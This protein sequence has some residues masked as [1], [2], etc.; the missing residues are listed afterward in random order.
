M[1]WTQLYDVIDKKECIGFSM[2]KINTNFYN[3]D[4]YISKIPTLDFANL[5]LVDSNNLSDVEDNSVARIN[6]GYGTAS[7]KPKQAAA[8]AWVTFNPDGSIINSYNVSS[9]VLTVVGTPSYSGAHN[10][11]YY[12]IT[13]TTPLE[14]VGPII[15]SGGYTSSTYIS[16]LMIGA[17]TTGYCTVYARDADSYSH[18]SPSFHYNE[19]GLRA[20]AS[21][22]I[23]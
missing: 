8:K 22:V 18:G 13:Y 12:T 14:T 20:P 21:V 3:I 19:N 10:D 4:D 17:R 6:L 16:E 5:Y 2:T 7:G 23:Y 9:V 11:Q 15:C 1:A